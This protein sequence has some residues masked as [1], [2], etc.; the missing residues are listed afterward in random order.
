M[1]E[2]IA[3]LVAPKAGALTADIIEKASMVLK[4]LGV[5]RLEVRPLAPGKAVDILFQGG[6]TAL[7]AQVLQ[8]LQAFGGIDSYVQPND[9][10]RRKK[11]LFA[12]MDATI[13]EGETLDD[14][15][16][17]CNLKDK[18]APIT[19]QAMRGEIDFHEA[20]RLRVAL[21]KGLP[22][23]MLDKTLDEMKPSQ[24]AASLVKTMT[25]HGGKCV[26]ISGGFDM[27]TGR[28]R[29]LLGF[30]KD[31]G[32]TLG[33]ANGKLTGEVIPPIVDKDFKKNTLLE[34]TRKLGLELR[35]TM[36]VG[37]GAN[38]IPMLQA[39][40]AGVGYFAK[41]A[42]QQATPHQVRHTDLT[43]LLYMQGYR[44]EEIV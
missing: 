26:L 28:I 44:T 34:E 9:D 43:A 10:S 6:N 30:Y 40:G 42:V 18:I 23:E 22:I 33:I 8:K 1:L 17:H 36:A 7:R 4:S 3:T 31:F 25:A 14:L 39:A 13:V 24:G 11:L 15:A 27:F 37:D 41:P 12:D 29:R 2:S 5:E 32:N 35:H 38:D 16:G 20:L 21:L 19:A